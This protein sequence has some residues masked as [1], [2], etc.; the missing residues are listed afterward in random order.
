MYSLHI[1]HRYFP[2]SIISDR[3]RLF[4]WSSE[5]FY[6]FIDYFIF[7]G[8]FKKLISCCLRYSYDFIREEH[9]TPSNL[10]LDFIDF[11]KPVSG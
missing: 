6:S 5:F 2:F 10:S 9:F 1:G 11:K 3:I 8:L 7:F 4:M